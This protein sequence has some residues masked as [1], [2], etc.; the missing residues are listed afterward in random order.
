VLKRI[1][2]PK[3]DEV[4]GE[5]KRL[6]K[7]ERNDLYSSTNIM[8]VIKLR[9]IRFVGHVARM[10]NRR[11]AYRIFEG[12]PERSRPLGR[13]RRRWENSIKVDL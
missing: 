7:E 2:E 5:W 8:Q 11:G 3:R 1:F 9:I 10:R 6:P 12:T 13:S 4:T